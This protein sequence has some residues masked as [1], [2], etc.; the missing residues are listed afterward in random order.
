MDP[1]RLFQVL[2]NL[3]QNAMKFTTQGSIILRAVKDNDD[4]RISVTD[5]GV[6]IP[7]Q[8][9]RKIFNKFH[10]AQWDEAQGSKPPGTGLGLAICKQ[11]VEH[12]GGRIWVESTP[13][14][15][16]SFHFTL[17]LPD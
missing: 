9:L 2:I 11:I 14:Q 16:S 13:G 10:Q 15:G 1:D 6:G 17:P 8:E 3:L 12:Y 5:T 7:E 4:I